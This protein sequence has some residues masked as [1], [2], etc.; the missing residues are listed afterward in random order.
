METYSANDDILKESFNIT[1]LVDET[2]TRISFSYAYNYAKSYFI[3]SGEVWDAA[4]IEALMK[5]YPVHLDLNWIR[6]DDTALDIAG[7]ILARR[8]NLMKQVSFSSAMHILAHD[9]TDDIRVVHFAGPVLSDITITGISIDL[10]N[11]SVNVEGV[12]V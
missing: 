6:D 3:E 5:D 10:D 1:P 11:L 12:S 9:L 2:A 8:K 4:S 7:K